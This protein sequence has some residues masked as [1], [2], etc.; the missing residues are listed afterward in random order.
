VS[1][2]PYG[3]SHGDLPSDNDHWFRPA[4]ATPREEIYRESEYGP[5]TSYGSYGQQQ[6]APSYE[7][8]P[9]GQPVSNYEQS[10]FGQP[11]YEPEPVPR[12]AAPARQQDPFGQDLYAPQPAAGPPTT[13]G[14][15][16]LQSLGRPVD[17]PPTTYDDPAYAQTGIAAPPGPYG[18]YEHP[19]GPGLP[20]GGGPSG[21]PG[22]YG[23][24]DSGGFDSPDGPPVIGRRKKP[25]KEGWKRYIPNW[26][27]VAGGV[28]L[29]ILAATTLVVVGYVT[30]DVPDLGDAQKGVNDQGTQV[31]WSDGKPL[32]HIGE[33]REY[34]TLDKIPVVI[35]K[36]VMAAEDKNFET[37][38]GVSWS[39]LAR[40]GF[41]TLTGG[42]VQGGSTI[43]QQLARNYFTGLSQDRSLS[44]KYK[45]I[46]IALKMDDKYDKNKVLELYLNTIYYGRR[47]NGIQAASRAYFGGNVDKLNYSQ[48]AMLAAMI[49][50]PEYFH[51][52]ADP[53]A[54]P[55]TPHDE[56]VFRW[57]YVLRTMVEKGWLTAAQESAAEFPRTQEKWDSYIR[58]SGQSSYVRD[59]IDRELAMVTGV[60]QKQITTSGYKIKTSLNRRLMGYATQAVKEHAP[61][62]LPATVRFGLVTVNPK[63]GEIPAFYAG[64]IKSKNKK[65]RSDA[66]FRERPQVGSSF[67]PY[68]LAA[69]MKTLN[70][71][72]KSLIEGRGNICLDISHEDKLG[73]VIPGMPRDGERCRRSGGYMMTSHSVGAVITIIKAMQNSINS[74]FVRLALK[75]GLANVVKT[76]EDF[77]IPKDALDGQEKNASMALGTTNYPAVY[78]AAGYA[79]F[80]NGGHKVTPHIIT[81]V[82]DA[83]NKV[84]PLPWAKDKKLP[85]VLQ[86]DQAAQATTAMCAVIQGGTGY[87]AALPGRQ[88]AGKTG[89]TDENVATW[90]VGYTPQLSTASV[91]FNQDNAHG[92]KVNGADVFGGDYA[93]LIWKAFMEKALNGKTAAD[94]TDPTYDGITKLFDSPRPK[95]TKPTAPVCDI[96]HMNDPACQQDNGGQDKPGCTMGNLANCDPNKPPQG[97]ENDP[98]QW[99]CAMHRDLW[100]TYQACKKYGG[101][102]QTDPGL[103]T[104]GDGNPDVTDDDDDNDGIPD[105]R[106]PNPLVSDAPDNG[107]GNGNGNGTRQ[108]ATFVWPTTPRQSTG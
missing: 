60:D 70:I 91:M 7:Q 81:E 23:P 50:R 3:P 9:F 39:G 55:D 93:A 54:N 64:N 76:A 59:E 100:E 94:F 58:Y 32:L 31:S 47:S 37:E 105:N 49:Q 96:L 68:V 107:N 77:G 72:V 27:M 17:G 45:E 84:I 22:G 57:K 73:D 88:A 13:S 106:D 108:P 8:D 92:F 82:R 90:F 80:A 63:N 85:P 53:K 20:G 51:T 46:F 62:N 21:P 14:L 66:V 99:W 71:N 19:D 79:A 30:T 33:P 34:L 12:P 25:Q 69:A 83:D 75:T 28:T 56:L 52:R 61:K 15:N 87:K 104:D 4:P 102:Q 44:R 24:G 65:T 41:K 36:A 43:T 103:D 29:C 78:Q 42:Q 1:N 2:P 98:P 6:P 26:K 10:P 11:S 35:Q 74:S 5:S 38:P 48:A 101:G 89:T 18:S 16:A 67:K 86:P 95:T 40:A 97:T